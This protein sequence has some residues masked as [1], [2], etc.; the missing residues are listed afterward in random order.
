[1][2]ENFSEEISQIRITYRRSFLAEAHAT[3]RM[4]IEESDQ[5]EKEYLDTIAY[6]NKMTK[7]ATAEVNK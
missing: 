7:D 5:R 2:R 4:L 3:K 6:L 1:M